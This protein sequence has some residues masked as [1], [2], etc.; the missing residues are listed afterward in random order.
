MEWDYKS[1]VGVMEGMKVAKNMKRVGVNIWI[2]KGMIEDIK[3]HEACKKALLDEIINSEAYKEAKSGDEIGV[4]INDITFT[5]I[6]GVI[7]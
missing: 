1:V 7:I 6:K 4:K 5:I 2:S 3:N